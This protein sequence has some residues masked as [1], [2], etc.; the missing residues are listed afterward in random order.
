MEV[1]RRRDHQRVGLPRLFGC[2]FG[3][4]LVHQPD[5]MLGRRF[6]GLHL[7]IE[8]NSMEMR[9][10]LIAAVPPDAVHV[11][12]VLRPVRSHISGFSLEPFDSKCSQ[13]RPTS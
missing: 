9:I 13:A 1:V 7:K 6:A 5:V 12:R 8:H 10:E 3:R 11:I 2:R 4:N